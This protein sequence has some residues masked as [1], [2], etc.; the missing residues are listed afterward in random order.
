[1]TRFPPRA[2]QAFNHELTH[3]QGALRW[4]VALVASAS[5]TIPWFSYY[6]AGGHKVRVRFERMAWSRH[7]LVSSQL[8]RRPLVR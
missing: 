3:A 4:P 8:R 6:F 2:S 5:T 1:M 7:D